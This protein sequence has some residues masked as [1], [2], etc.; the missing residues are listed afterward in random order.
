MKHNRLFSFSTFSSILLCCAVASAATPPKSATAHL[1]D[2]QGNRVGSVT[3]RPSGTGVVL[4]LNLRHLPPGE[5]AIHFHE[6]AKCDPPDFKSAGAHFNPD[7]KEHGLQN[8][9]G[10]H[11]GDMENFTVPANGNATRIN[12]TDRDVSLGTGPNSLFANGGTSII[13]HAKPDD[14]HTD[15]AG[16][17][18]DRIA[19]GVITPGHHWLWF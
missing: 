12:I 5:H 8:P 10:H 16:N 2:A 18:G 1:I 15:P 11:A 6:V 7:H 3:I 19:C 17:S 9:K 14:R 4:E 13:V